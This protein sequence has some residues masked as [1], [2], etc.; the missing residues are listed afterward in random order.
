MS[1]AFFSF[2]VGVN[3]V[4]PPSFSPLSS[5]PDHDDPV[6]SF[7]L[8]TQTLLKQTFASS[9]GRRRGRRAQIWEGVAA[10]GLAGFSVACSA[11]DQMES[12]FLLLPFGALTSGCCM[13]RIREKTNERTATH[14]AASSLCWRCKNSSDRPVWP[15]SARRGRRGRV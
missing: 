8:V 10:A 13:D 11:S 2:P 3:Q 4:L 1:M 12:S 15:R 14:E 6:F 7:L 5:S 9:L